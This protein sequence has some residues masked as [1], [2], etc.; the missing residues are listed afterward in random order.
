MPSVSRLDIGHLDPQ[1]LKQYEELTEQQYACCLTGQDPHDPD[2]AEVIAYAA[3]ENGQPIGLALG[4]YH[5]VL[6]QG[7]L[8]TLYVHPSFRGKGVGTA[9]LQAFVSLF[10]E[11]K[12]IRIETRF[13]YNTPTGKLFAR[14]LVNNGWSKPEPLVVRCFYVTKEFDPD[15]FLQSTRLPD[16]YTLFPWSELDDQQRRAVEQLIQQRGLPSAINP[17][18]DK[19]LIEPQNSLGVLYQGKVVGWMVTHRESCDLISYAKLYMLPEHRGK[20]NPIHMLARSIYLQQLSDVEYSVFEVNLRNSDKRW[21]SFM[22]RRLIPYAP[23]V[24]EIYQSILSL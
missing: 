24:T 16:S 9:L 14:L 8:Y 7:D 11:K 17:F 2:D 21:L 3:T 15:W 20:G 10:K 6:R 12:A 4:A 1:L 13:A 19:H 22:K 18:V 5:S 23:F